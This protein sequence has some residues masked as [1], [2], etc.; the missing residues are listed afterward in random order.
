MIY[1]RHSQ[2]IMERCWG[3]ASAMV[4]VAGLFGCARL[5]NAVLDHRRKAVR[6][7]VQILSPAKL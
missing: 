7:S 6:E 2:E 5:W 3:K 4:E 1:L